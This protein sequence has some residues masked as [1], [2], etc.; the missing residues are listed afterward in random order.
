M[1]VIAGDIAGRHDL[2]AR[3]ALSADRP[4]EGD[5]PVEIVQVE[6]LLLGLAADHDVVLQRRG[7]RC[8]PGRTRPSKAA[9]SARQRNGIIGVI[10]FAGATRQPRLRLPYRRR[11]NMRAPPHA[12]LAPS[13]S[14]T[15]IVSSPAIVP[16]TSSS[17]AASSAL[18]TRLADPGGVLQ[19]EQVAGRDDRID[20]F[21]QQPVELGRGMAAAR[22]GRAG[23]SGSMP[24]RLQLDRAQLSAGRG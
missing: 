6:Q 14:A 11:C 19:H 13:A 23:H 7:R 21:G 1:I 16:A 8:R 24:S 5:R 15:K 2:A 10:S 4:L 3:S 12:G 9:T 20:P 17:P 18:A 22:P